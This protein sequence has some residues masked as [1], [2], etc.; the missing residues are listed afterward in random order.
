MLARVTGIDIGIETADAAQVPMHRR[1]NLPELLWCQFGM[2]IVSFEKTECC[3]LAMNLFSTRLH[4]CRTF[5][6]AVLTNIDI[7]STPIPS[8]N[9]NMTPTKLIV[10]AVGGE[11]VR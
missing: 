4:R 10:E 7:P 5:F 2:S 6:H 11:V 1:I 8:P 9:H 3:V